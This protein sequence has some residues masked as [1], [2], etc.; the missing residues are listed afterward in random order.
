[1]RDV[2]DLK[3]MGMAGGGVNFDSHKRNTPLLIQPQHRLKTKVG[4]RGTS[5]DMCLD[6][7]AFDL[8]APAAFGCPGQI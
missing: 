6:A 7:R 3:Y 8:T 1:M 5:I 2:S 4:L